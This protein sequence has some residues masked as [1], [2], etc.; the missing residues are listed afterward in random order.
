MLLIIKPELV[1]TVYPIRFVY[2]LPRRVLHICCGPETCSLSDC[3][4]FSVRVLRIRTRSLS[5]KPR[6]KRTVSQ[7]LASEDGRSG[8]D[9]T[10]PLSFCVHSSH[11]FSESLSYH[12]SAVS[13]TLRKDAESSPSGASHAPCT[14]VCASVCGCRQCRRSGRALTMRDVICGKEL[15]TRVF[16]SREFTLVRTFTAH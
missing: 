8:V 6:W 7:R 12:A 9:G 10:C 15:G 13:P 2:A 4:N 5:L 3:S 1:D 16:S 11:T 14:T